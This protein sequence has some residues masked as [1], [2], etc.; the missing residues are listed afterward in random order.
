M[1]TPITILLVEDSNAEAKLITRAIEAS[2]K[3]CH[4]HHVT[5]IAD[6]MGM[7]HSRQ[8]DVVLLDRSL[9]DA[10]GLS[11]LKAVQSQSPSLPIIFVTGYAD[12]ATALESISHG[13]QDYLLKDKLEAAT[14]ARAIH[15]AIMRKQLER[16]LFVKANFDALTGMANRSLFLNRLEVALAKQKRYPTNLAVMYMDLNGFKRINDTYGHAMADTLLQQVAERLHQQLRPY[17]TLA[18]FGGDEFVVLLDDIPNDAACEAVARK[19]IAS[20]TQPFALESEIHVGISI[21]IATCM[22]GQACDSQQL[23]KQADAAMYQA[24]EQGKSEQT[25]CFRR[26]A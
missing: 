3:Q 16:D 23:L 7:L 24:K 14:V 10:D 11:G 17:D 18:R 12:E 20:V 4:I 26:A 9:P 21:G 19:F 6:A 8:F 13:A 1:S 22:G 15:F 25:S 2:I 5:R